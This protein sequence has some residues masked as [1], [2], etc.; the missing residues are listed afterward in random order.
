MATA[1]QKMQRAFAV[2]F[3]MPIDDLRDFLGPM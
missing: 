1:R 3:L 2:Q